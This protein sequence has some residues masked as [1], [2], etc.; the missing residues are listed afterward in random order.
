MEWLAVDTNLAHESG[1]ENGLAEEGL[2]VTAEEC[3]RAFIAQTALQEARWYHENS[4]PIVF[5]S[6]PQ[7]KDGTR[8]VDGKGLSLDLEGVKGIEV[9]HRKSGRGIEILLKSEGEQLALMR[10]PEASA[11]AAAILD[12]EKLGLT[13]EN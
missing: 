5:D 1:L 12:G 6:L 13:F 2:E 7:E 8:L 9:L 11:L 10:H 4:I 3:H